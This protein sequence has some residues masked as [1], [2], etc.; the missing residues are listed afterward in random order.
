MEAQKLTRT[1][2]T[3]RRSCEFSFGK[4]EGAVSVEVTLLAESYDIAQKLLNQKPV[5]S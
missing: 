3:G 4:D 5:T 2:P 1:T